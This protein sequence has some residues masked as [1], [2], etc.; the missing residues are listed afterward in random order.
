M[1]CQW[2][3]WVL[4]RKRPLFSNCEKNGHIEPCDMFLNMEW[5]LPEQENQGDQNPDC[6]DK[7]AYLGEKQ[8]IQKPGVPF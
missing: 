4:K 2:C 7:Q 3:D 8:A 6:P 1:E 5:L